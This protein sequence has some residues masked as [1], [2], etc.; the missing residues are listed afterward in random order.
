MTRRC[1]LNPIAGMK[2]ETVLILRQNRSDRFLRQRPSACPRTLGSNRRV[3]KRT[4]QFKLACSACGQWLLLCEAAPSCVPPFGSLVSRTVG[5]S[6]LCVVRRQHS[7]Y[8]LVSG[9]LRGGSNLGAFEC[10]KPAWR[11]VARSLLERELLGHR[12]PAVQEPVQH[13]LHCAREFRVSQPFANVY[14]C[15]GFDAVQ[16]Q[17]RTVVHEYRVRHA[18]CGRCGACEYLFDLARWSTLRGGPRGYCP[19]CPDGPLVACPGCGM[20]HFGP[21]DYYD[22]PH[23]DCP[24]S[25][26]RESFFESCHRPSKAEI[27]PK[28]AGDPSRRAT[29]AKS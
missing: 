10:M 19:S 12:A 27:L 28:V 24:L 8:P 15:V 11:N 26:F 17:G 20:H 22:G 23:T 29:F 14:S 21:C 4:Q 13:C 9:V 3:V 5:R 16:W 25:D 2:R 6:C 1:L 18:F 7:E